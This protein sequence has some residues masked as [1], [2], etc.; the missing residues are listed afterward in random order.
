MPSRERPQASR[1]LVVRPRS[2]SVGVRRR[3]SNARDYGHDSIVPPSNRLTSIGRIRGRGCV[4]STQV[5]RCRGGP[6]AAP[7]TSARS[8][9]RSRGDRT[10]ASTGPLGEVVQELQLV[11]G[12]ELDSQRRTTE[13]RRIRVRD[14]DIASRE[15]A[16]AI[17]ETERPLHRL[18][19]GRIVRVL[20]G[21]HYTRVEALSRRELEEPEPVAPSTR[22]SSFP[23]GSRAIPPSPARAY[24]PLGLRRHRRIRARSLRPSRG[25]HR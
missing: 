14:V 15:L 19:V 25:I 16:Q 2:R 1:P 4:T 23:S 20:D 22:T 13:L 8:R 17:E 6:L 7:R 3:A 21:S 24:R 10:D 11:I 18:S 12:R 9:P 5:T